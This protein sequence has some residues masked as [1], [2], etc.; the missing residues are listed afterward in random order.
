MEEAAVALDVVVLQKEVEAP[1][2]VEF[3]SRQK[4]IFGGC[5]L[6]PFIGSSKCILAIMA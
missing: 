5:S 3:Q 4:P 2:A 6:Y 1:K